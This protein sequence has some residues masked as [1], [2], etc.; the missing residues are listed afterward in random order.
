VS[1]REEKIVS[2]FEICCRLKSSECQGVVQDREGNKYYHKFIGP[3]VYK[4]KKIHSVWL[5]YPCDC[6]EFWEVRYQDYS[7][8]CTM[9]GRIIKNEN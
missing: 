3:W 6:E 7:K 1:N 4:C 5:D 2:I 9:L 8:D